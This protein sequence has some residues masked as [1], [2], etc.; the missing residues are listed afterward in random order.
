MNQPIKT[1]LSLCT[2]A[3]FSVLAVG[4]AGSDDEGDGTGATTTTT[5]AASEA[6]ASA[7]R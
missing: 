5:S 3:L 1:T 6:T 4:T 7:T 2:I